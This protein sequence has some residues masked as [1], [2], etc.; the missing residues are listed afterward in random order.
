MDKI[1]GRFQSKDGRG[2][3]FRTPSMGD[4]DGF[5]EFVNS[6]VDEGAE[7]PVEDRR[8]RE[9]EADWLGRL[10]ADL[11][12]GS[13][14]CIVGEVDGKLIANSEIRKATGRRSHVGGLAVA[15]KDGFRD[16]GI[17]TELIRL[18]IEESRR[19]GLRLVCLSVFETNLRARH[20]YEKVGF[21]EVGR[22]PKAIRKGDQ[23]VDEVVMALEL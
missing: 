18:L 12:K 6:L 21:R 22:M 8:S 9:A 1:Y 20:V 13:A 7:I 19:S 14:I 15:I 5:L 11:E 4:L 2:V 3:M 23:Y 10:L 17:G 16:V